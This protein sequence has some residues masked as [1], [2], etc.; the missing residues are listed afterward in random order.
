VRIEKYKN[1]NTKCRSCSVLGRSKGKPREWK[2]FTTDINETTT[3]IAKAHSDLFLREEHTCNKTSKAVKRVVFK[4]T[5]SN[6]NGTITVTTTDTEKLTHT[7]CRSCADISLKKRPYER[8]YNKGARQVK[9]RGKHINW[10]LTYDE[11]ASLCEINNCHYC[12]K[13]LN[14]SKFKSD[15]KSTS[16][17]LDRKDSNKD[18]FLEN[19][20]PCCPTCNF[21]KNE[22]ISYDEMVLIMKHRGCWVDK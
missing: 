10:S 13:P 17:L 1:I 9:D 16:I 15:G 5:T 18:Y 22:K 20:V 14:R 4:C 6:C 7:R 3:K 2:V 21:T 8:T 11:F 12:N 19:C